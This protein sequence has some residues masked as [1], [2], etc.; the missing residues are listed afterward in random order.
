MRYGSYTN[1]INMLHIRK[2]EDSELYAI[3]QMDGLQLRMLPAR[4]LWFLTNKSAVPIRNLNGYCFLFMLMC[5]I[6]IWNGDIDGDRVT[7]V[8]SAWTGFIAYSLR[9]LS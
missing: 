7:F 8:T 5:L 2:A 3:H 6:E 4:K 9:C 1:N